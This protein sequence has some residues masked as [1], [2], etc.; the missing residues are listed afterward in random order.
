MVKLTSTSQHAIIES[1]QPLS[2]SK[3][4]DEGCQTRLSMS[5]NSMRPRTFPAAP[6]SASRLR[7]RL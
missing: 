4:H 3:E 5:N 1:Y 6:V 7:G 2:K